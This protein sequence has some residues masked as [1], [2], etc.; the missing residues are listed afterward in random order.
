MAPHLNNIRVLDLTNVLAGPFC[1][2]QLA[3]AGAEVIKVERP[4]EG[5]LARRLGADPELSDRL[6]GSSF[7]AQNAGKKS[8]TLDFKSDLGKEVFCN[9]VATADVV[10]ENFRPGV[11]DRLG[12]GY[13]TLKEIRPELIYCAI[14]GFGQDGPASSNPA[15]DQIVQGLSGAMDVTGDENSGP[16]RSGFPVA[17]TIGGLTA[18]FAITA[19]LLRRAGTE[20][21]TGEFI[22]VSMLDSM[23]AAMGWV[24]SNHLI[25]G[26]PPGRIGNDNFTAS[27]SGAFATAKGLLNIAANQQG[28]FDALC[29]TLGRPDLITDQ[30]FDDRAKRLANREALRVELEAAL[31]SRS[32]ADW[33]QALNQAGVPAGRVLPLP[34]A[35][36][37][38]QIKARGL[39]RTY[40]NVDG[41]GRDVSVVGAGFKS[42]AGDP[43]VDTPPPV[44]GVDTE[45][46]LRAL[47]YGAGDIA[48]MRRDGVI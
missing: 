32:S 15:Y 34:E 8:I 30:R 35:F 18:A 44:L 21:G 25:A 37:Q 31:A 11:M 12:L 5:D 42:S 27:P 19:A 36:E 45:E 46:I 16:L 17:D 26:K 2:Y 13:E 6:M 48:K 14:S 41:V 23:M 38:P 20:P 22:D 10:V 43:A 7:L 4:G 33:E 28:Q 1:A 24:V 3:L 9:L 39:V 29:R 40:E 47:G